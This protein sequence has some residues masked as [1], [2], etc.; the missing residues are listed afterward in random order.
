MKILG[1]EIAGPLNCLGCQPN[2]GPTHNW[3]MLRVMTQKFGV[4]AWDNGIGQEV[5][6]SKHQFEGFG[7]VD[8]ISFV[9][10]GPTYT[11]PIN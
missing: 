8:S 11:N 4:P 9:M 2:S 7:S 1:G 3:G 5:F 10:Y 6:H